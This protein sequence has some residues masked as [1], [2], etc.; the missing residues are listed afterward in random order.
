MSEILAKML[1]IG[2]AD[3]VEWKKEPVELQDEEAQTDIRKYSES[4]TQ[5]ETC[6]YS[7]NGVQTTVALLAETETQTELVQSEFGI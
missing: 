7:E 6:K 4:P 2:A 5:T 1:E 3:V